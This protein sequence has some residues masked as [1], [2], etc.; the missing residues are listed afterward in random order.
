MSKK[1]TE[2]FSF[3]GNFNAGAGLAGESGNAVQVL[4]PKKIAAQIECSQIN[5]IVNYAQGGG[6]KPA[7]KPRG[8]A[9]AA[10]EEEE[11]DEEVDDDEEDDEDDGDNDLAHL[12]KEILNRITKIRNIHSDYEDIE[13]AYKEER[14]ALEKKYLEK[15]AA[16]IEQRRQIVSGEVEV[17]AEPSDEAGNHTVL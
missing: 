9:A 1:P 17:P 8:K 10:A 6:S 16:V 5:T 3:G 7:W 11:E 14:I 4:Y 12:P 2:K 15:K 13:K